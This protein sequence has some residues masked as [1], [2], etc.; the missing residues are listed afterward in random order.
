[1]PKNMNTPQEFGCKLNQK[2]NYKLLPPPEI[3]YLKIT[4]FSSV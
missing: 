1:M 3:Q 2:Y 4:Y